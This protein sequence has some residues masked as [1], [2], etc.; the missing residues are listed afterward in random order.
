MRRV[1]P[2]VP[3]GEMQML[4][5]QCH[6][7]ILNRKIYDLRNEE[8]GAMK[9]PL[10]SQS[11]R[12]RPRP[13]Y[14]NLKRFAL[15]GE[16]GGQQRRK[17]TPTVSRRGSLQR[18][19]LEPLVRTDVWPEPKQMSEIEE[20]FLKL[21]D[22]DD[23]TRVRQF[24]IDAKGAVVSRGD[25]FRRKRGSSQLKG[26]NSPS[27]FPQYENEQQQLSR[28]A[29]VGS[30]ENSSTKPLT[31][32]NSD[33]DEEATT[34][35]PMYKIYVLG[36][37]GSGKSSLIS[38]FITSEYKNAFADEIEDYENT[39]SI[40]IGG[41][42]SDLIFFEADPTIGDEW[43]HEPVDAYLL[44]YSIDKK[45]SFKLIVKTL[46]M[47]RQQRCQIPIILAGNKIDLERKRTVLRQE[48][49]GV[50]STFSVAHFEISVALNHDVDDLLVGI[51]A[52]I[53]EVD[54][55]SARE[56]DENRPV[57]IRS[58]SVHIDEP[59]FKAAIRRFSQ[60]KKKQM[61]A[62]SMIDLE[63]SKCTNLSPINLIER[64]RR[65]RKDSK[66]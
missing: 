10:R 19:R 35:H 5:P 7:V 60:R 3:K 1:L 11:F 25:S 42:E 18:P 66:I 43:L 28:S 9:Q 51:V 21:P 6:S 48:V 59:E 17:S 12:H 56:D 39:V 53:K 54:R 38:Q 40:S 52:E 36:Q 49:K 44:V 13:Q 61:G 37:T 30:S 31:N 63:G 4:S 16:M 57:L 58:E 15:E 32:N 50:G 22:S 55:K 26:E 8:F 2:E 34:S 46:E 23:Y 20:R 29:S 45:S 33:Q 47:L 27:P 14:E 65:W 24:N 62:T 41:Q 64:F